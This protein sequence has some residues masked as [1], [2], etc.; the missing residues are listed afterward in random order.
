MQ[1]ACARRRIVDQTENVPTVG[2][3]LAT[4]RR[5]THAAVGSGEEAC[6]NLLFKY[7]NLLA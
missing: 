6:A 3:K 4:R 1:T 2:K 7:L 5:Q